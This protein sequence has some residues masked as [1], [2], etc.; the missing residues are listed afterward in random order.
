MSNKRQRLLLGLIAYSSVGDTPLNHCLGVGMHG[1][2]TR[3]VDHA[4]ADDGLRVDRERRWSFVGLHCNSCR[5][6]DCA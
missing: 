3:T 1:D 4:I 5:H 2:L 6:S